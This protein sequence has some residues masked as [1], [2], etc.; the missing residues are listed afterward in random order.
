MIVESHP[1]LATGD[2]TLRFRDM[3]RGR[4]EVAMGLETA[5]PDVLEKLNKRMTL[6]QFER[7]AQFLQNESI[8]LRAFVLV[9]PPF[10]GEDE[11]LHWAC[12]SIDFAFDCGAGAVSLIPVRAGNGAMEQLQRAGQ[13]SPPKLETVVQ[14]SEY[15]LQ[16]RRGRVFVDLWDIR[17]ERL[18]RMNLQQ[19]SVPD[20]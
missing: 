18:R 10:T 8:A 7:A 17:N 14:A 3:L 13:F 12:R 4:L 5:Q 9:K 11:A 19:R 1:A 20:E 2:D 16:L 15:G 6:E